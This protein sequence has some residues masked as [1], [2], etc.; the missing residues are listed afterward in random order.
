MAAEVLPA[1]TQICHLVDGMPLGIELAAAK[2]TLLSVEQIASRLRESFQMLGEDRTSLPHLQTLEATIS[3][4]Y[5]LLSEEE[6]VVLQRLSVFSGGWT[7]D[8]AEA[9][10]SDERMILEEEVLELLS[11]LVNKSLVVADLQTQSEARYSLLRVVKQYSHKLLSVHGDLESLQNRHMD[12]FRMLAKQAEVGLKTAQSPYWLRRLEME[13]GNLR[14]AIEYGW[15]ANRY[16]ETLELAVGLFWLWQ[17]R[18]HISEGRTQLERLL[19]NSLDNKTK[20]SVRAKALWAAGSLAWIQGDFEEARSQ[21]EESVALWR[22]DP[23]GKLGLA[24]SLRELGIVST[25]QGEL[26]YAHSILDESIFLL[27]QIDNKWNLALACYNH[28]LIHEAENNSKVARENFQAS[29][30]MFR[31]LNEPWGLSVALYG[32]GRIAGRQAEYDTARSHLEESLKIS[33]NLD[34]PWSNA[35]TLYLLG[36]VARFQGDTEHAKK[37][38]TDSLRLN[39]VV[40]DKAMI[41]FALHNLGKIAQDA[42]NVNR[43]ALLFGAAQPLREGS[44]NTSSWSL[45]D[46]SQCEQDIMTLRKALGNKI[47]EVGWIKGQA[48]SVDDAIALALSSNS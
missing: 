17:T 1:I 7:L 29:L 9:V 37:L 13:Q 47:F 8:A 39:Q 3:W 46:Q 5:D 10:I 26:E 6:R 18:G 30:S 36:E 27:Q 41:G 31:T 28:G 38:Y 45:T 33:R 48:M 15:A 2:I 42:D 14:A 12:F 32:F 44:T 35:G 4:S 19:A 40:G 20:D 22:H 21:L 43:A 16:E 11:Q 34:D 25:Y 23:T 24:I